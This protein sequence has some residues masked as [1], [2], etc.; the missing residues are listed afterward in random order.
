MYR[1]IQPS[2]V[3]QLLVSIFVAGANVG[4]YRASYSSTSGTSGVFLLDSSGYVGA[5]VAPAVDQKTSIFGTLN[6]FYRQLNT[7]CFKSTYINIY[8][9]T[10]NSSGY[11]VTSTAAQT[12]TTG[13]ALSADY[14]AYNYNLSIFDAQLGDGKFQ[15]LTAQRNARRVGDADN[16]FLSYLVYGTNSAQFIFYDSN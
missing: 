15:F 5:N 4:S 12:S 7:D 3:Q 1:N 9:E 14:W 11:L 8:P 16:I 6:D 2:G 13:Y 10:I